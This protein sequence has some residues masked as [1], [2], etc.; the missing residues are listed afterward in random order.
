MLFVAACR[1]NVP[2]TES[3]A[4][5]TAA[6]TPARSQQ[7][8]AL[9]QDAIPPT[10]EKVLTSADHPGLTWSS[11]TDIVPALKPLYEAESDRLLWFDGTTPAANIDA[12]LAA[13]GDAGN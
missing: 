5:T 6:P 10:V 8:P 7:P 2:Q 9:A 3:L 13:I 12:T 4:A 11:I 1:G